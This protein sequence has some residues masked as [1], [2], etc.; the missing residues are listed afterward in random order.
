MLV[1]RGFATPIGKLQSEA[2]AAPVEASPVRG[3][4]EMVP[5]EDFSLSDGPEYEDPLEAVTG[6]HNRDEIDICKHYKGGADR[7]CFKGARCKKK[8]IMKH[9]D[10]WTLDKI[11]VAGKGAA[12][13]LP[14]PGSWHK[15]RVSHVGHFDHLHVQLVTAPAGEEKREFGRV[16]PPKTLDSL[17]RDMNSPAA[18]SA[19]RKLKMAPAPGELVAALYTPDE[20]W[21]RAVVL[22][23]TTHDQSVQVNQIAL[24]TPDEQ[25]YRAVV[26]AHTTHD[27]SVRYVDYGNELWVREDQIRE[28]DLAYTVLPLQAVHCKLAGVTCTSSDPDHW[29]SAKQTLQK[30]ALDRE[31]DCHIVG[32]GY[33]EL[34]IELYDSEGYSIADKLA[35]LNNTIKVVEYDVVDDTDVPQRIVVP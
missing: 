14:P 18:R 20:Q 19:H 34:E 25:W 2:A 21:Y 16:L 17:V 13:P 3:P 5:D 29:L 6:Y 32:R 27:Q 24:Y 31:L 1:D 9:P 10:G 22:A 30:L 28:L 33:D 15:A 4:P 12:T 26:L 11:E 7:T 35:A 8:H 23:H